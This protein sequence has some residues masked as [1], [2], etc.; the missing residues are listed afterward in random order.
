[1]Y[2]VVGLGNPG[3]Q[4]ENTRH[5]TGRL[6]ARFVKEVAGKV[7]VFAPDTY[8]NLTGPSVKK[9]LKQG[10]KLILLHDDLDLPLGALRIS[11]DRGSGGHRGVESVIGALGT[12]EFARVRLGVAPTNIF[13]KAKKPSAPEKY[14]LAEFRK[15][16]MEKMEAAFVRA[17]RAVEA[18]AEQG[19]KRAMT[20]FNR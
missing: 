12:R 20:E 19:L 16:E 17:A 7:K 1:M 9:L 18:I 11:Y 14:V 6:A 15:K 8:M 4:Y 13:G 2:I 5:N 3:E 10:D